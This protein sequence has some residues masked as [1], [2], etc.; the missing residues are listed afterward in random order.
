M[1][2]IA[3]RAGVAVSTVSYALSG[4]RPVAAETRERIQRA[5]VELGFQPHAQARA[6]KSRSSRTLALFYPGSRD[7]IELESHIFLAGVAEAVSEAD[8]SLLVSTA[9]RDPDGIAE[10]LE[11]GRADG[12]ILMEVRMHDERVERLV[13]AG[14]PFSVIGRTADNEGLDFVDFDFEDAVR[15]AVGYLHEL[16]HRSIA[17][18]DR[19]SHFAGPDFGPT[20]RMRLGFERILDDLSMDGEYLLL[21]GPA[22][23]TYIRVLRFLERKSD[24][25]AVI[26][27]S[28]TFTPLLA[29]LRDL[30]RFVPEDISVV[31]ITASQVGDL[32]T[33]PLTTVELPAFEMGRLGAEI[34]LRRLTNPNG[35]RSQML[36][37]GPIQIRSS[38][39]PPKAVPS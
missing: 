12:V 38:A 25:T 15:T 18:L 32:V 24:C 27:F 20:V 3:E 29:A 16:G 30:G 28:V 5:I 21:I 31:A 9:S 17:L 22:G 33:P 11:T 19:G 2:D 8:Y 39:A 26:P 23:E 1:V 35:P 14:H 7:R 34:L 4:K 10:V 6:L 37:R 13:R 36:L